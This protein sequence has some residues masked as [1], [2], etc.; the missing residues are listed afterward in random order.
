[1]QLQLL[2]ETVLAVSAE[3]DFSCS[4]GLF[5]AIVVQDGMGIDRMNKCWWCAY[6]L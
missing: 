4:Y 5:D 1:M 2:T 6:L 3:L